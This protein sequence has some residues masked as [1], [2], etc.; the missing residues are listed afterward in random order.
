MQANYRRGI[1]RGEWL[2]QKFRRLPLQISLSLGV[3]FIIVLGIGGVVGWT[4]WEMLHMAIATQS[5]NPNL[6]VDNRA[7]WFSLGQK[8]YVVGTLITLGMIAAISVFI[9]FALSPVHH[10]NRMANQ[11]ASTNQ[12]QDLDT[13]LDFLPAELKG[14]VRVY[15]NAGAQIDNM[16]EQQQQLINNISHEL[17]T[18]LT[19]VYG[20][21]Q[22]ALRH[23]DNLT[24]NQREGLELAT[25][26]TDR[27][28]Y[29]LQEL[30]GIGRVD[31]RYDFDW[32]DLDLNELVQELVEMIRDSPVQPPS[33]TFEPAKSAII[34]RG[35]RMRLKQIIL[36]LIDQA[37]SA[38]LLELEKIGDHIILKICDRDRYIRPEIQARMFDRFSRIDTTDT[39]RNS[40]ADPSAFS[41]ANVKALIEEMGGEIRIKSQLGKGSTFIITL[42][43]PALAF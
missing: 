43:N 40:D 42:P 7:T 19:I 2:L 21:L 36:G 35:D 26:E 18:P 41:L 16:Q 6:G 31:S 23:G 14:L 1:Y 27:T 22:S 20:Y 12:F 10:I 15:R 9:R 25:Q 37:Q 38:I 3:G 24:T 34:V 32:E 30:L 13:Q 4:S 8:L 11:I 29:L 33:I 5:N 17:R 39:T 28:I